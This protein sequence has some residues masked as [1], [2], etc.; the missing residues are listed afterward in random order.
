V[1]DVGTGTG[2]IALSLAQELSGAT[3]VATDTSAEA[4]AL[5]REN[6]ELL[7]FDI[8]LREG[9][10]LAGAAGPFELVVSNP[11]YV[12]AAELDVLEPEVRD[13]EPRAALLD[14][15]QTARLIDVARD[16]LDGALVLEV[17]EARADELAERLR[18]RGYDD[19]AVSPDLTG[20]PRV[21]E[22]RWS[23][24]R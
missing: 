14:E 18:A 15:G 13:W 20:R 9:D 23:N 2:A 22:G 10:L 5:A 1:L 12:D 11:P 4:L 3:V 16:V 7:G 24:A 8:E 21:V 19:V 6:I 17:H